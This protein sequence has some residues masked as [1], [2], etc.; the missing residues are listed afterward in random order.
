MRWLSLAIAVSSFLWMSVAQAESHPPIPIL[1][2]DYPPYSIEYPDDGNPGFD[3]EVVSAAFTRVKIPINVQFLPW[4]RVLSMMDKGRAAGMITC[5]DTPKRREISLLSDTI[6]RVTGAFMVREDFDGS[7]LRAL[8]DLEGQNILAVRGYSYIELL[9]AAGFTP[10]LVDSD[11]NLLKML[12]KK[13]G[14]VILVSRE[15]A[16]Y[17]NRK[18][19]L[20]LK[21][22]FLDIQ[23]LPGFDLYLCFAKKYPGAETLRTNFNEGLKRIKADG[24]YD[25]IH[26]KY[27]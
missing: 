20:N 2:S 3:V 19:K 25:A 7:N 15:N 26:N 9:E 18:L 17:L 10:F 11:E 6:S 4:A 1:V 21:F 16:L 23:G 8:S 24:T 14:N 12:A 13:R 5:A 22:K 27:R